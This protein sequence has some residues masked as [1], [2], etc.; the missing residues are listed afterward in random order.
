MKVG[1]FLDWISDECYDPGDPPWAQP[2]FWKHFIVIS[3]IFWG[4]FFSWLEAQAATPP[5]VL[6]CTGDVTRFDER[7]LPRHCQGDYIWADPELVESTW[8]VAGCSSCST[9]ENT[10]WTADGPGSPRVYACSLNVVA[11]GTDASGPGGN[12][13]CPGNRDWSGEGVVDNDLTWGTGTPPPPPPPEPAEP[14]CNDGIDN[15]GDLLVD[16]FDNGCTNPQDPSEIGDPWYDFM[17]DVER[18]VLDGFDDD[19]ERAMAVNRI[20]MGDYR[21]FPDALEAVMDQ[22]LAPAALRA[23]LRWHARWVRVFWAD[24]D[25]DGELDLQVWRYPFPERTFC[26][27]LDLE[28]PEALGGSPL[29]PG[30]EYG[31]ALVMF[32][33]LR[34]A[35]TAQEAALCDQPSLAGSP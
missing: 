16:L 8:H 12:G 4:V 3:I 32:E 15:D 23:Q 9:W 5:T 26:L 34:P 6:A 1:R 25:Q 35:L 33:V 30:Q 27:Y 20:L 13:S 10:R 19:G 28:A 17:T 24:A 21:P 11:H 14:D 22:M 29:I 18:Q 2:S 31:L 7:P